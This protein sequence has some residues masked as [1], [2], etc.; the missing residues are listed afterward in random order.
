MIRNFSITYPYPNAA[1]WGAIPPQTAQGTPAVENIT[2]SDNVYPNAKLW[3]PLRA[4]TTNI[5]A[6]SLLQVGTGATIGSLSGLG[7]IPQV[8]Q[9]GQSVTDASKNYSVRSTY[10]VADET[11]MKPIP[12]VKYADFRARKFNFKGADTNIAA[13]TIRLDGT[14]AAIRT[15]GGGTAAIYAAAS[16][17]PLG[18]A[19]S[20]FNL[21]ATYGWGDH[22]NP[23]AN[24]KDFTA[25]SNIAT[26]WDGLEWKPT[27]NPLEVVTA[28]RG[29]KVTVIDYTKRSLSEAYLWRPR[30]KDSAG[31][32]TIGEKKLQKQLDK[33]NIT[34]DFIKFFITGPT[35]HAGLKETGDT[36]NIIVFRAAITSLGDTFNAG[37]SEVQM[38]GRADPN[39]QYSGYS[40]DVSLDFTVYATDRDELKPIW[41]KLNALAGYT[42]PKY[43]KNNIG[44][45]APWIRITIGDIFYQQA[46]VISSL[47]YT[48]YDAETPW[49]INIENDP[50][51]MQVP[52]RVDV[53]LSLKI[54]T[55]SLPQQGGRFFT[56]A[57]QFEEDATPKQGNDN[58]LSD[59][60]QSEKT[61]G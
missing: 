8:T 16:A 32:T 57:K 10:A 47:Q 24:R 53:S 9:I 7:G 33:L 25:R 61:I 22:D 51:M 27:R 15:P 2:Y 3:S 14:S 1:A 59:F 17:N 58:W 46:A 48:Y 29:D 6:G 60:V 43:D 49:E 52:M 20:I 23:Y 37:W 30:F 18:G 26:R 12:G 31:E 55:D 36:D 34:R 45:I 41:R 28:F 50:E 54:V 40:R 13:A 21:D 44:M 5:S 35:L 19:Y 56:L 4:T 11:Q 39:F 38:I 42:A